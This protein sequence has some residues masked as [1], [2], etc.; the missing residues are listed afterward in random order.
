[1]QRRRCD[2]GVRYF[3][4]LCL[5]VDRGEGGISI[6]K[7]TYKKKGAGQLA[8]C[9][10]C[11]MQTHYP[12]NRCQKARPFWIVMTLQRRPLPSGAEKCGFN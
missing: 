8:S 10:Y 11:L 5:L 4:S 9:A 3:M 12:T 7:V 1:M 6:E 2:S